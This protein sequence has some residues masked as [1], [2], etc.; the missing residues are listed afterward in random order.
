MN[1]KS[2]RKVIGLTALVMIV[3]FSTATLAIEAFA[4]QEKDNCK[5]PT[6]QNEA[7]AMQEKDNCKIPTTENDDLKA[8]LINTKEW[9]TSDLTEIQV[10]YNTDSI[11]VMPSETQNIVLKEYLS[12]N[13]PQYYAG[14]SIADSIL[15]IEGG[16]RPDSK[17]YVSNI[18]LYVPAEF[19]GTINLY[20][21]LGELRVENLTATKFILKANNGGIW[22]TDSKGV[23]DCNLGIGLL[24]VKNVT[25]AKFVLRANNGDIRITDSNG[26]L[27]CELNIGII[28]ITGG[29]VTGTVTSKN[30]EVT[31]SPDK[32][33]GN[34]Q[35]TSKLGFI[36]AT[37]PK[38]S[39]FNITATTKMSNIVNQFSDTW[40]VSQEGFTQTLNGTWGTE[41]TS[42]ISLN[43]G[44]EMI[45]IK[46]K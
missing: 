33:A 2:K 41:P 5:I 12:E 15:K 28:T 38:D 34:I 23:L 46:A 14:T 31:F 16:S 39:S 30:G 1:T 43:A 37:L 25:A 7:L 18:E 32:I 35:V 42:T 29:S 13:N 19:K 4:M 21:N 45:E 9:A 24:N 27:D 44:M 22:V 40:T 17:N 20:T 3:F 8:E 36:K 6:T 26:D 11:R 10:I